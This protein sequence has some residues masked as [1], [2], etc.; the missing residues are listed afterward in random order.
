[1]MSSQITGCFFDSSRVYDESRPVSATFLTVGFS[2]RNICAFAARRMWVL[3]ASTV[4]RCTSHKSRMKEVCM[5]IKTSRPTASTRIATLASKNVLAKNPPRHRMCGGDQPKGGNPGG[6]GHAGR[7][8]ATY[9]TAAFLLLVQSITL[10]ACIL[11]SPAYADTE[12][13]FANGGV[14]TLKDDGHLVGTAHID[15][16]IDDLGL[17]FPVTLPDGTKVE[18]HC[19]NYMHFAPAP[20]DYP[21]D[22]APQDDGTYKVTVDSAKAPASPHQPPTN[23]PL[24]SPPQT[25][26][27]ISW[28]P[29]VRGKIK[30]HKSSALPNV[31]NQNG[32]YSLKEARYGIWRDEACTQGTGAAYDLFVQENGESNEVEL[33]PG[34][35]WVKEADAPKGYALDTTPHAVTI[36]AG[37]TTIL[38]TTDTPLYESPEVWATKRDVQYQSNDSG[39]LKDAEFTIRYY[40]G[41]FTQDNLPA[42]PTRTWILKSDERG[43]IVPATENLVSGDEFYKNDKGTVIFPI[44][45]VTI[46]ETKAPKGYWLEG[47][48]PDSLADYAAPIHLATIDG[49]G[50]YK[51]V[52]VCDEAMRAGICI[53]KTDSQT[54]KTPQGD[55][56]FAGIRFS[57]VN[58]NDKA[59]VVNGVT[60]DVD[61]EIGKPLVT[62]ENGM[63]STSNDYL[64]LGTYEV[65]ESATNESMLLMA[66]PQTVT[67]T[68]A[69]AN[70]LVSLEKEMPNSVVRGGLKVGK[71]SRE[72]KAHLTQGEAKLGR[73]FFV[74]ELA[75]GNPVIVDGASH[76]PGEVVCTLITDDDGVASTGE[77]ALPFGTYTVYEA[78]P[79]VG[80]LPND[81]WRKT[82]SIRK[83]GVVE[84][85]SG[86]ND[87]ADDQVV[88][89]GF[90]FNKVDE[91]SM[92]R[93][94]YVPWL[95][96]SNSTGENHVI[97]ADEN[98]VVD[99]EAARHDANTNANDQAYSDGHVDESLLDANSGIWF[100]GRTDLQT[101]PNNSMGA[102]PYDT[103]TVQELPSSAN[104]GRDL[105]SFTVCV[106]HHDVRIDM[107][108]VKNHPSEVPLIR[109]TLTYG[110]QDHVAPVSEKITLVDTVSYEGLIP[111]RE[112]TLRGELHYMQNGD[113]VLGNDNQP[114][115]SSV[116]FTPKTMEGFEQ[117]SFELDSH[118][119]EGATLVAYEYLTLTHGNVPIASHTAL[120]DDDQTI[121]F[122]SI[123]T[124]LTDQDGNQ[125]IS[126]DE[127][128]TLVDKVSF[129][130]LVPNV[131]YDL[132]GVL[133]DKASEEPLK[134]DEG[135]EIRATTSFVPTEPSGETE[136]EF[137]F[138]GVLARG[139]VL[140]AFE[141]L[142][143]L[144]RD[145]VVHAQINDTAQTVNMP[146]LRTE[147]SDEHGHHVITGNE[148]MELCDNISYSGLVSRTKYEVEGTLVYKDTGKPVLLESGEEVHAI[149]EF[150]P[151]NPTGSILLTFSV[152][153]PLL[154]GREIV[155]FET[156]RR[157]GREVAVHADLQDESQTAYVPMI[158]TT[159][160]SEQGTHY[161]KAGKTSL[162]DKVEYKA[163]RTG[164]PYTLVGSLVD[165]SNGEAITSKDDNPLKSLVTFIPESPY[166]SVD[167]S[168]ELDTTVLVG[169]SL[170]AFE[171]LYEGES[172]TGRE[173]AIH[174]DLESEDQTINIPSIT[175]T[176]TNAANNGKTFDETEHVRIKDVVHYEGLVPGKSY[177]MEGKLYDKDSGNPLSSKAN[178]P[179]TSS[180]TF[181]P[182]QSSGDVEVLFEFDGDIVTGSGVVAFETCTHD[183]KEVAIHADLKDE[184]QTVT[185]QRSEKPEEKRS[186][187]SPSSARSL[188]PSTG[189]ASQVLLP[190]AL[191]SFG[192]TILVVRRLLQ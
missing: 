140:V 70:K 18:G 106:R 62:D 168:F 141:T 2:G 104:T 12:I 122:P 24:L 183:D 9:I 110:E 48:S 133:M 159:L 150:T 174:N 163:L 184:S 153:A 182:K 88:R 89:G 187:T 26:G 78:E 55:A 180:V 177:V 129:E 135:E 186:G 190:V 173:V 75:S 64:P 20:G 8:L 189:D 69:N 3:C 179:V 160:L 76:K 45:T 130:N 120:D 151:E 118:G 119:L 61:E 42:R 63:A 96:T 68:M 84:D 17:V 7:K 53:Q 149:A 103:Y 49:S 191:A 169:R 15:D 116:T 23:S 50:S 166:G 115:S 57:I 192:L 172:E 142:S 136:V 21:F 41:A 60:Y 111:N 112:Y 91:D 95:I 175:T 137:T 108:T 126:E 139:K 128:I 125:E 72:T 59:I 37:D 1:M 176:A 124:T 36:V 35:Y 87:S 11:P 165:K 97:I 83:D 138:A 134:D 40:D 74:V 107:G 152:D 102:L 32:N 85:L 123:S 14:A 145:L 105:V 147:F 132:T 31:S 161:A 100:S 157:D 44:G 156:L 81:T 154:L 86:T 34:R 46:Q 54:G 6:I 29:V 16:W 71:I 170:V 19:L 178:K 73:A 79:P 38:D 188:V 67:L 30:L 117:V 131:R 98:G 167:V 92:D 164:I 43:R 10:L 144:G 4:V 113:A 33:A 13:H 114:I 158:H 82:V 56:T 171:I 80:Y 155:A 52:E 27:N 51:A 127:R 39:T 181:E 5:R 185:I 77:R 28:S 94:P 109:T 65:R 121:Y 90:V 22:A 146:Y 47:Q 93:M 101:M 25:V 58:K 148:H 162:K 143:R 66:Q 99:T